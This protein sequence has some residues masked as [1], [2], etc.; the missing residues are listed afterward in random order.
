MELET[1]IRT[2]SINHDRLAAAQSMISMSFWDSQKKSR[3]FLEKDMSEIYEWN[4]KEEKFNK[5]I[6]HSF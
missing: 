6:L 1:V 4:K 3:A 2:K 5:V